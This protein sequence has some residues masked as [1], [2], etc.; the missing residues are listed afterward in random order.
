M[1]KIVVVGFPSKDPEEARKF[2]QRFGIKPG[3]VK[4]HAF[5]EVPSGEHELKFVNVEGK[6]LTKRFKIRGENYLNVSFEKMI[7]EEE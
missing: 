2:N 3:E 7:I 5:I 4:A 1:K 6:Q